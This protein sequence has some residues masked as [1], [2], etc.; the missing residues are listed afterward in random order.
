M[1]FSVELDLLEIRLKEL[2]DQVDRFIVLEADKAFTGKPKELLL[3]KNI[4]RFDW[5]KDKLTVESFTGL[6]ELS[7]HESP[8]VNENRMRLEMTMII[9]NSGVQSGDLII[10]SD[11]D[12]IPSS[13]TI[14]LFKRCAGYPRAVHL[15]LK[16]YVTS[17]EFYFA[18]DESWRAHVQV[19]S[20]GFYYG[21][22]RQSNV[23]LP[24]AGF[25]IIFSILNVI[26]AFFFCFTFAFRCLI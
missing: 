22:G 14:E 10:V 12:E 25:S 9:Q 15:E 17:F 11:V 6:R 7:S 5:A 21:H 2:W 24:D 18:P 13:K 26:F 23:I 8:F 20:S 16:T 1:I 4:E 3:K 19:Y